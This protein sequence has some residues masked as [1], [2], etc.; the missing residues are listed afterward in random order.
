MTV[1]DLSHA[2][3]AGVGLVFVRA[4][5]TQSIKPSTAQKSRHPKSLLEI[6]L[7]KS[8]NE[9]FARIVRA[10]GATA[11][12]AGARFLCAKSVKWRKLLSPL[13]NPTSFFQPKHPPHALDGFR[14]VQ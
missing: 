10:C 2:A 5:S 4:A 8:L 1:R 9:S 14:L 12:I 11:R 3:W 13:C 7:R 6:G